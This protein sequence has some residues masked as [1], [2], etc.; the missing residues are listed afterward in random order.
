MEQSKLAVLQNEE[1]FFK[2]LI[3]CHKDF[4]LE[5]T[6]SGKFTRMMAAGIKYPVIFAAMFLLSI[7]GIIIMSL[8][9]LLSLS[10]EL[11]IPVAEAATVKTQILPIPSAERS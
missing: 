2:G 3:F 1:E 5:R 9:F 7:L 11:S 10:T 4:I 6:E 8:S